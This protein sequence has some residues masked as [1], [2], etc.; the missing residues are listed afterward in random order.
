MSDV[1]RQRMAYRGGRPAEKNRSE[2]LTR[3]NML[4]QRIKALEDRIEVREAMKRKM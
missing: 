4:E 2:L 1:D 3:I